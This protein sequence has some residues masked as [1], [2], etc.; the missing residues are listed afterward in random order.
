MVF[1][2]NNPAAFNLA[3]PD[4]QSKIQRCPLH[5]L[6]RLDALHM[7]KREGDIIARHNFQ[8]FDV[9][10]N[11]LGLAGIK[12]PLGVFVGS[13]SPRFERERHIEH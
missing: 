5:A 6:R 10:C 2:H 7:R 11:R 9:E 1:V 12:Q 3:K 4:R 13:E 8:P